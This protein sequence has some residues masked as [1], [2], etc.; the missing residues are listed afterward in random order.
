MIFFIKYHIAFLISYFNRNKENNFILMYHKISL[1]KINKD[2]F[3]VSYEEFI[4]QILFLRYRYNVVNLNDINKKKKLF[5][6][7]F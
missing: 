7:H 3:A 2:I 6:N 5:L 4:K 1:L